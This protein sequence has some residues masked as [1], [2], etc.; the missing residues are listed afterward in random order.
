MSNVILNSNQIVQKIKR[1]S[2]E[3]YENNLEEKKVILFG[4][5]SN[6]NILSNRIKKNLDNLFPVNIESYNLK[7]DVNNSTFNK[8][9]LERDSLNGKVVIIV[10]DVLNSGK[11]IAYSINLILP[12]YPKKIEVA[13]LVDR[14]HKNF[15]ILAKYSGVKLNTTINE[16][17]KIDFKKN[18]GYLL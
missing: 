4:I 13:V 3:L 11:T 7:V 2:Y 12:F 8:L 5:N 17:V 1:L 9:D 16:H 14:S 15:P 18:E 10:D 6:G